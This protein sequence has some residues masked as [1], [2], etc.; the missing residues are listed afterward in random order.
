VEGELR[1]ETYG[2]NVGSFLQLYSPQLTLFNISFTFHLM[3][4]K[5]RILQA[6]N[7]VDSLPIS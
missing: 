2:S 1:A 6:I 7:P 5:T 3:P 4:F